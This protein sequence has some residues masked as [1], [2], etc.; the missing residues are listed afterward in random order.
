MIK[1]L[2]LPKGACECRITQGS[3]IPGKA[4]SL[5]VWQNGSSRQ[6]EIILA[7]GPRGLVTGVSP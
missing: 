7:A 5:P 2:S 6:G 1:Y 4:P 3:A